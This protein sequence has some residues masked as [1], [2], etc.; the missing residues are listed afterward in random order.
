LYT[1]ANGGL[2]NGWVGTGLTFV[3]GWWAG[4]YF[5]SRRTR[6]QLNVKFKKEQK[7][8]YQQY[9]NDVYSL[10]QQNAELI[11]ALEQYL[12]ATQGAG[13]SAGQK[14]TTN[15]QRRLK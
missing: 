11:N 12:V 9:Y 14:S 4:G 8:L 6:N 13:G 2:L 5:H 15:S 1:R 7:E 3:S 10:Q